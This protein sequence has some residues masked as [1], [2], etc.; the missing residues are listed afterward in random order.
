VEPNP[1]SAG[2][3]ELAERLRAGEA[4]G[5]AEAALVLA[6]EFQPASDPNVP[7]AALDRLGE[8]A[9]RSVSRAGDAAVRVAG[10]IAFLSGEAGFRGNQQ[11]YDEP[12]NSFLDV[13]LERRTG[14]PI[15]LAIVYSEVAARIGLELQGVSF[16]GHFLLRT[17]GEPP[18]VVD[19]F[20]GALLE[21]EDCEAL[22]KRALGETARLTPEWLAPTGTRQ[23][24]V[25]MLGNLK[26]CH[27]SRSDWVTAL[28]CSERILR[29]EPD[30]VGELRDRGLLWE[31]LECFGPALEDLERYLALVPHAP[32]AEALR[33]RIEVLRSRTAAIH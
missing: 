26:H 32:E 3:C 1:P 18:L 16:P 14:I 33:A 13:V 8:D 11:Q 7:L 30:A 22:L 20:H 24:V 5:L 9:A 29:V 21:I 23:V 15:T 31:K 25:R 4:V 12:R 2:F 19:A 17:P 28:D 27:A 10:L 6:A